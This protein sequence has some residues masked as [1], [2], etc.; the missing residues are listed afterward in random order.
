[1][2]T[3]RQLTGQ[4]S[5]SR[6]LSIVT[7]VT[8]ASLTLA[9]CSESTSHRRDDNGNIVP[10]ARELDPASTIY[11]DTLDAASAGDCSQETISVLTCYAY[12][13]HG[14]EGAQTALGQCLIKAQNTEDGIT[15]L[16]RAANAGWPDAQ[17]NLARHYLDGEDIGVDM[18]EAGKW[19]VLY[20]KNPSLLSLGVLPETKLSDEIRARLSAS[21]KAEATRRANRW[22]AEFWTP[23]EA[24]DTRA[25]AAC[26]VA[27]RRAIRRD[28]RDQLIY[29]PDTTEY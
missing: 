12:R 21:D 2:T 27:P 7:L 18:A 28:Q 25:A 13:G 1:M 20:S 6:L 15:W 23:K 24:L 22:N 3:L 14:Y 10:T 26:Y 8:L 5:S 19:A 11:S 29:G 4:H 9:A 16:R 17:R